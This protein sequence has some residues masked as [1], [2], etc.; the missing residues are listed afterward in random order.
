MP[1]A[2]NEQ[3][4]LFLHLVSETT[5]FNAADLLSNSQWGALNFER[6]RND[7]EAVYEFAE[8]LRELPLHLLPAS[9]LDHLHA[10]FG[11]IKN[12]FSNINNFTIEQGNPQQVRD[13]IVE[14]L[15]I[16]VDQLRDQM[17][18]W[19]GYLN[20]FS[21]ASRENSKKM[22]ALI[23]SANSHME[24]AIAESEEKSKELE[25]IISA[26]REAVGQVGVGEYTQDFQK[27]AKTHADASR[28]W[29]VAAGVF[30]IVTVVAT[31]LF[32]IFLPIPPG[33]D[34]AQIIQFGFTKLVILGLLVST[35]LW[36][37]RIYRAKKHQET[38]NSHRANALRTFQTFVE[39]SEDRQIRDAVLL[40]ATRSIF[41]ITSS[42]YLGSESPTGDSQSHI[43]EVVKSAASAAQRSD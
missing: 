21:T 11:A 16:Q 5:E 14:E 10:I 4:D 3:L 36:C 41:A 38:I 25:A 32:L 19:V 39:A 13:Q 26:S 8:L 22:T 20:H 1:L 7:V 6:A 28:N 31:L 30:G 34:L 15:G 17:H 33:S 42:G 23:E 24:R 40:E 2:N 43:V 37:A 27:E 9:V 29:L 35:T 12:T 18:S